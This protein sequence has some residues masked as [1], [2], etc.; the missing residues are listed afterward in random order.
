MEDPLMT[1]TSE[2]TEG[3]WYWTGGVQGVL[4]RVRDRAAH[5]GVFRTR[6]VEICDLY[7]VTTPYLI[8]STR[9]MARLEVPAATYADDWV[10]R[11]PAR[12]RRPRAVEQITPQSPLENGHWRP[13]EERLL[14]FADALSAFPTHDVSVFWSPA[15]LAFSRAVHTEWVRLDRESKRSNIAYMLAYQYD[16]M[17]GWLTECQPAFTCPGFRPDRRAFPGAALLVNWDPRTALRLRASGTLDAA[18]IRGF[19]YAG[20]PSLSFVDAV[21]SDRLFTR[22]PASTRHRGERR[23][24]DAPPAEP[25]DRRRVER[26]GRNRGYGQW[27]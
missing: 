2:P 14:W 17:I 23:R 20:H 15:W 24:R 1:P 22:L 3:L 19:L 12:A 8:G 16:E 10:R 4:D 7:G 27:K 9:I 21:Y 6:Y 25:S 11:H 5:R 13:L 26:R 18:V